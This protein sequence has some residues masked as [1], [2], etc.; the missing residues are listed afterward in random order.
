MVSDFLM[1]S[2]SPILNSRLPENDHQEQFL[3]FYLVPQTT[4]MLPV[5]QLTEVLTVLVGQI[6]PIPQMPPWVLGVYN[7]RGEIL[8]MIDLG[9]LLGL[10]PWRQ[11]TFNTSTYRAIVLHSSTDSTARSRLR[12]Q[13]LGLVVSKVEDI[14]WC[15]PND[16]QSPPASAVT[17]TFAPFLRGY[18]LKEEGDMVMVLDGQ[19]ILAAM[20]KP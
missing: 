5:R 12:S 9:Q 2:I 10:T 1:S 16:I 3:R 18:W 4:V 17:P 11:Q 14:E 13:T 8:W 7:W 15:N 6:I 20:P 19:A